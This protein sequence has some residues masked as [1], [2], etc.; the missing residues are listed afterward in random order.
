MIRSV[1]PMVGIFWHF[2]DCL[3]TDCTPLSEAEP[4]GE[5]LTHPRGHLDWWTKL[6]RNREVPIDVEYEEPPRGRVIFDRR[7]ERFLLLADACILRRSDLVYKI[8]AAL[9]LPPEK[10][11]LDRDAHYRCARCLSRGRAG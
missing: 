5:C 1:D 8:M 10:T 7:R 9:H 6:Q 2:N 3:I 11:D 4:Y